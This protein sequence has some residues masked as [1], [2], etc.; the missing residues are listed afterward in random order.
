MN[1]VKFE[2]S[3]RGLLF[4]NTSKEMRF[5]SVSESG[6]WVKF[7]LPGETSTEIEGM[8]ERARIEVDSSNARFHG[9]FLVYSAKEEGHGEVYLWWKPNR[10]GYTR[11]VE[12]A[13]RY[14]PA[15]AAEIASMNR[16]SVGA[17][18]LD[19]VMEHASRVLRIGALHER[20]EPGI[21]G[22]SP[23]DVASVIGRSEE[24][25]A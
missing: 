9:H 14:T 16:G 21:H 13:G 19:V 24:G 1:F 2:E 20:P 5:V 8:T 17:V 10:S 18:P 23:N 22:L 7:M 4:T 6:R 12:E 25:L 11:Y 3:E 15:E